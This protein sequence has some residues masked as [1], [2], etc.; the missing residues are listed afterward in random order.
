MPIQ[1]R[2]SLQTFRVLGE[3]YKDPAK[4]LCGA[5]VSLMT[6]LPSGTLYPI[7]ARLEQAGY[8]KSVW[9]KGSPNDLKRPMKRFY[10]ITEDGQ[11]RYLFETSRNT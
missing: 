8:L 1:L 7:L 9:E 3:F 2:F 6:N 5:E 4:N 11:S 10:K